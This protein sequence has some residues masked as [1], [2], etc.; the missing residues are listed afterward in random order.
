MTN[1]LD[2]V[3]TAAT[4]GGFYDV[5]DSPAANASFVDR[6]NVMNKDMQKGFSDGSEYASQAIGR[7]ANKVQM[8]ANA[9]DKRVMARKAANESKTRLMYNSIF[10]DP[11]Q[12]TA[13]WQRPATPEAP[14]EPDWKDMYGQ[15]TDF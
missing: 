15:F 4:L 12:S 10:G 3:A 6:Y 7:A 8:N 2:G 5:D 1:Q 13:D 14:K 11:S 9:F